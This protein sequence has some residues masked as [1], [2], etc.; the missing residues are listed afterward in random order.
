MFINEERSNLYHETHLYAPVQNNNN[1]VKKK[2]FQV[3]IE[4]AT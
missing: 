4:L 1:I 2:K 3:A